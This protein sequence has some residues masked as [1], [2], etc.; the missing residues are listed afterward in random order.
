VKK[1]KRRKKGPHSTK[2]HS[3]KERIQGRIDQFRVR[4]SL[5]EGKKA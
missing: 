4:L 5:R 3:R 1:G 2:D